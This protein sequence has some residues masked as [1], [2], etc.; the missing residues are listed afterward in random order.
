MR[1][2]QALILIW[3]AS[4]DLGCHIDGFIAVG[5]HT[6]VVQE[7]AKVSGRAA[8]VLCAASTAG[9]SWLAL[10]CDNMLDPSLRWI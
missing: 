9:A 4:S 2:I 6:K 1:M 3:G 7:E 10:S 8:D 5:A